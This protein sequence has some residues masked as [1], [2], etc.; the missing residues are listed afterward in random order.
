MSSNDLFPSAAASAE[1]R[2]LA[3]RFM[4]YEFSRFLV[5]GTTASLANLASAWV[6]RQACDGTW[7]YFEA[8]VALGFSVGTVIS[9]VL[10]KFVTFR[11]TQGDT[12]PQFV[13]FMIISGISILLSIA[14]A[15]CLYVAL[16]LLPWMAA[17]PDIME[18][19]AHVLTIGVIMVANYFMMKYFAFRKKSESPAAE[20]TA[21]TTGRSSD[22]ASCS[23]L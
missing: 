20:Q 12:W 9:F 3:A 5:V 23:A 21:E 17:R 18:S 14:V 8:S 7:H 11:A 2:S 4:H 19:A 13:R 16:S 1:R 10:N 15:H 6:Y 22:A